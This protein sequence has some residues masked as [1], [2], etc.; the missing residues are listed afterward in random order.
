M[1]KLLS[2]P[3][4]SEKGIFTYAIDTERNHLVKTAAEYHP[5]IANYINSA[6]KIPGKTQILL[7]ALGAG[8]YWGCF[9][10]GTKVLL[11]NGT[12]KEIEMI[13]EGDE[14]IT[15][16]NSYH[17]VLEPMAKHYDGDIYRFSPRS[18]GVE[19]QCTAEHPL[20]VVDKSVFD[21]AR[22]QFYKQKVSYPEFIST[23][24]YNFKEAKDIN[25]GDYL[26]VPFP[27]DEVS[28]PELGDEDMA[29]VFG[30]YV[31]E[32]NLV[33]RYDKPGV[34]HH[35]VVLTLGGHEMDHAL[36]IKR[37][38]ESHGREALIEDQ[39]Q[40]SD[41]IRITFT[42]SEFANACLGHFGKG[43]KRKFLSESVLRMPRSWQKSFIKAYI[44]GD[45]SQVKAKGRY[46]G[47][48]TS[49]TASKQ[50]ALGVAKMAA[51]LGYRS[52]FFES[53]QHDSSMGAGNVIY[54]NSYERAFSE[55]V[56]G[57]K[58]FEAGVKNSGGGMSIHLDGDRGYLLVPIKEITRSHY[59]GTVYNMHVDTDNSYC[60]DGFAVHNCNV[61]G[62][63]FPEAALSHFGKDYGYKTFEYN[64]KIYKHH[65]NKD[66]K[67]SYG[68][69]ALAVY[70]PKYHRVE[71]IVVL[72]NAKA[73]DIVE[74][75][76]NGDYPEWSM[77]CRVP[78]DVCS[79]C[80]HKAKT[81]KEY[82]EHLKYYIGRIHP[83]TGKQAYAINTHPNFFDISQVLI[84]ADKTAKTHLKVASSGAR[85]VV[86]SAYIAEK[87]AETKEATIE[88]DIP[89]GTPPASQDSVETL[90]RSI[91]EIKAREKRL[92]TEV[93]D[94]LGRF[95]FNDA[96]S[97]LSFL[98]ILPKPQEFQRILLIS[99][100]KKNV[101][102]Q[103]DQHNM[104]FD[105]G[106][107]PDPSP[108]HL[109]LMDLSARRFRP[110]ILDMME[111]YMAQRS[112]MAPHLG[113]RIV[114][115]EK[116]AAE[117]EPL[118]NFIKWANGDERKPVGIIPIMALAAGL[119]AAFGHK[120]G[121][122]ITGGLDKLISQH[123]QLAAA[124]AIGA[125]LIFN[126]V[127]GPKRTGQF[128][129]GGEPQSSDTI[130]I[131]KRIEEMRQKPYMKTAAL[132]GPST[133]R[134]F[135]GI[136]AVYMASGILQK[137]RQLN[138][139]EQEGRMKS[140]IRKY[141]DLIGAGLALDALAGKKGTHGVLKDVVPKA[142]SLF[143][144]GTA[145]LGKIA[146]ENPFLKTASAHDFIS[147]SLVWPI[148]AGGVNLPAKIVGGLFDQA[149]LEVSKKVLSNKK[150]GSKI[151]NVNKRS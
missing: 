20:Y 68:D 95:N 33:K 83:G 114:L 117:E 72:D 22:K 108:S 142:E 140:F 101:A 80:G 79:I 8:E 59:K 23:L 15:H 58:Y 81:T 121:G 86:S 94:R 128:D 2:F 100:G 60:V 102:D 75:I 6:Q 30:W 91:P 66:P 71:L 31:A 120:A 126:S 134:L 97:T 143:R 65:I 55:V 74:R 39:Y 148:A 40:G 48:I 49:S 67:A 115:I 47:A 141:P 24:K 77:G 4:K 54:E 69:V 29:T 11:S 36:E 76:D 7:T 89:S 113:R 110:E 111:P 38:V 14:V 44:T 122:E 118:P 32:G 105:P 52:S 103:L 125:P 50:L 63:F 37:I 82:C 119:Y 88:K 96:M 138:P 127:I 130:D 87:M 9:L 129:A 124:L 150:Q 145:A 85:P 151:N 123:P 90:V 139:H 104:C 92:P 107:V 21:S 109:K 135:L 133:K 45:G 17:R 16:T 51:R 136:P 3:G 93:L 28:L 10:E 98:G 41:A 70:N 106:M 84:G 27:K 42:W 132:M 26:A 25:I 64:A 46:C 57:D 35:Q 146:E 61:N 13:E 62:D 1:E 56:S 19:L 144:K 147:N 5:E 53:S 43:A 112:Y 12:E 73:P 99:I 78:Y 149:V 137:Q 18:W 131:A 116:T 34:L